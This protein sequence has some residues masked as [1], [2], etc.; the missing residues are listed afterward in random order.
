MSRLVGSSGGDGRPEEL[1]SKD[2]QLNILKKESLSIRREVCFWSFS[3]FD[4]I[5]K[6]LP[7]FCFEEELFFIWRRSVELA[8]LDRRP[9]VGS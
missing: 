7:E 9:L 6:A 8:W 3:N 4:I 2:V 1:V 5:E